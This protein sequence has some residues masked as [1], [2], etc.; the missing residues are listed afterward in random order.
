M[1][2]LSKFDAFF[3]RHIT[4]S[5]MSFV[6][7]GVLFSDTLSFLTKISP[8]LFAFMT[9]ASSLSGG[10]TD[11]LQVFRRPLPVLV[12]F[13]QLHVILPLIALAMGSLLFPE[14]PL[15]TTGLVLE[16]AVP[17]GV[18]SL[19]WVALA[20]GNVTL[21]LSLV[22]LDTLC[23]PVVIPMTMQLLLGSVVQMDTLGMLMDLLL[24]IA[25]PALAAMSIYQFSGSQKA[26]FLKTRLSP[27][28][29]ICMALVAA[30]NATS[31][32][33]FLRNITPQLA[34]LIVVTIT[35]CF[36]GFF[37]GYWSGVLF[38]QDFPSVQT[39]TL[40]TGLRNINAGAV[41]ASAYFPPDVLFP[42]AFSPLFLQIVTALVL[43]IV[44]R[45][46][47]GKAYFR[48]LELD[49]HA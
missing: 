22:L 2:Y 15:F 6:V 28:S 44:Q 11:L 25:L 36:L 42:A 23:A 4:L 48:S 43:H 1:K 13:V 20:G 7:L 41:L 10:F 49:R 18:L 29:K 12:V 47:R 32:G 37:L 34:L 16:Y 40:N 8:F 14:N 24:M 33:P 45:T 9:F 19:M 17:T 38:R 21:C 30:S 27:F 31:C 35:L 5:I 26:S 46:R 39:M 3:S